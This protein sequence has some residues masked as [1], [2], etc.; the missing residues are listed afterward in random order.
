MFLHVS[1]VTHLQDF[2][3]RI[4]FSDG[5]TRVVD[6]SDQ[7]DG[8]VFEPLRDPAFF[9]AVRI[10]PETGTIEWPNGADFAPEFLRELGVEVEQPA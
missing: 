2:N 7:L 5:S 6:L 4:T 3:L 9:S 8:E 10:N 1:A